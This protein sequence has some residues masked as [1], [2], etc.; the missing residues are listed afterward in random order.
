MEKQNFKVF[1]R[2][3]ET[4]EGKEIEYISFLCSHKKTTEEQTTITE[5]ETVAE[6]EDITPET[7]K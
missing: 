6:K 7:G 2:N 4:A 5:V 1:I 3:Q